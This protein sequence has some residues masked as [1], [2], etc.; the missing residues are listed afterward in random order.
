MRSARP[1]MPFLIVLLVATTPCSIFRVV[2]A[3]SSAPAVEKKYILEFRD[4]PWTA[5]FNWLSDETRL[6]VIGLPRP[7]GTFTF[8]PSQVHNQPHSYTLGEVLDILNESLLAQNCVLQRAK[9]SFVLMSL[10]DKRNVLEWWPRVSLEELQK[11]GRTEFVSVV[12]PLQGSRAEEFVV[13]VRKLLSKTGSAVAIPKNSLLLH[14]NA[15][16]LRRIV[17]IVKSF[18]GTAPDRPK[19]PRI[20]FQMQVAPWGRVL[21]WLSDQSGLPVI[22][23]TKPTGTFT[24][25]APNQG[26]SPATYTIIEIID[27]INEA[28]VTQKFILVRR[29]AVLQ[30]LPADEKIEPSLVPLVNVADLANRGRTELVSIALSL[31]T[32]GGPE[33]AKELRR[34]MGPFGEVVVL[35]QAKRVVLQDIAGN[36]RRICRTIGVGDQLPA[37]EPPLR[38]QPAA[39][40]EE[41]AGPTDKSKTLPKGDDPLGF[42]RLIQISQSSRGFSEAFFWDSLRNKTMRL[43]ASTGFDVFRVMDEAGKVELVRGKVL[44]IRARDIDFQVGDQV[45]AVHLGDSVREALNKQSKPAK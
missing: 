2:C 27:L 26:N 33:A 36:L 13:E 7:T 5:V 23:T 11:Y 17:Q 32:L 24:F 43:R 38:S 40:K 28:L 1:G 20:T 15:G 39:K 6:P 18:D 21:E 22:A 34:M 35:S 45:Y 25:L 8:V 4:R 12:V 9:S 31:D 44:Q 19:E 14:D 29:T 30:L 3:D 41:S 10:A 16:S 37:R 42:I